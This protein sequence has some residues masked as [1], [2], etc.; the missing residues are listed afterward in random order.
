MIRYFILAVFQM[1]LSAI[2]VNT[3]Y[4]YM[5]GA[6][7]LVKIPVDVFIFIVNYFVQKIYIFKNILKSKKGKFNSLYF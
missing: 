1:S 3:I 6:E 4:P 7:I 2:L 5:G